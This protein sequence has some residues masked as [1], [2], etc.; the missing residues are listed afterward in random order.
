MRPYRAIVVAK[1]FSLA[2]AVP[3]AIRRWHFPG[4][5]IADQGQ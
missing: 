2:A 4:A 1:T 5:G 3:R